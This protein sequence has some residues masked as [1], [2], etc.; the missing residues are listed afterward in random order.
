MKKTASKNIIP[1]GSYDFFKFGL[2]YNFFTYANFK[3]RYLARGLKLG[4]YVPLMSFY[5]LISGIFMA[6]NGPSDVPKSVFADISKRKG[7]GA[8]CCIQY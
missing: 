6:E 5:K 1:S 2:Q 4:S 8:K 3:S 7:L